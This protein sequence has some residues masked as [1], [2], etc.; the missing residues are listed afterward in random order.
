MIDGI[1][2]DFPSL[3]RVQILF[4]IARKFLLFP[5]ECT[6]GFPDLFHLSL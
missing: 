1:R 3:F 2:R 5:F 4:E 6:D